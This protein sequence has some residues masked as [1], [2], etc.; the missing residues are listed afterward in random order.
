MTKEKT[1]SVFVDK[2]AHRE[3]I[4]ITVL[5]NPKTITPVSSTVFTSFTN[6]ARMVLLV[7]PGLVEPSLWFGVSPCLRLS[8]V[9]GTYYDA[10]TAPVFPSDT[11]ESHGF[12]S[13]Q[14]NVRVTKQ[15]DESSLTPSTSSRIPDLPV[16]IGRCSVEADTLHTMIHVSIGSCAVSCVDTAFVRIEWVAVS[17]LVKTSLVYWMSISTDTNDVDPISKLGNLARQLDRIRSIVQSMCS[18]FHMCRHKEQ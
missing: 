8:H 14:T 16:P 2:L 12:W 5:I 11:S 6:S 17:L 3:F 1:I 18:R 4:S 13:V 9:R 15:P 7:C 10:M